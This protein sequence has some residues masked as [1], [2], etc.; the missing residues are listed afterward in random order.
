MN[1]QSLKVQESHFKNL[2]S[3]ILVQAKKSG[4]TDAEASMHYTSGLAA[5]VRMGAVD[6]VEFNKDK[7][8]ELTIYQGTRKGTVSTTDIHR[9]AIQRTI[10]AALRIAK[11][12]EEDACAGLADL[13]NLVTVFPDLDLYHPKVMGPEEAIQL[14]MECEAV[15]RA[16]DPRITQS[17]GATFAMHEGLRAYGN[18][19]GFIGSYSSTRYAL[20]CVLVA[21]SKGLRQRDYDFTTARDYNDLES[22]TLIGRRA[23]E[24]T[25]N[26]LDARK[27]KTDQV[28]VIFSKEI[29]GGIWQE[30]ISAISGG[31]LYRRSSFLV[32]HLG[33]SIFPHF[34]HI[35]EAPHLLKGLGSAP[36]DQ[37][38]VGTKRHDIVREGR[39][40]SYVLGSYSARK[41][42]LKTTG[43]SGGV[44]NVLVSSGNLDLNGLLKKM[45]RGLLITELMGHGVNLVTGDYS[46]G[47]TGFWVEG[48][49]IQYPVEEITVAGNLKDMFLNISDIG[50]DIEHRTNILTGSL[51][52]ENMTIGGH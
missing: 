32:D 47:A 46:R 14:A 40:E 30:F 35:E 22:A 15:A 2:I 20:S 25:V 12:T 4:A 36:F 27:V 19:H 42:G 50:C 11:Y 8:L 6:T 38:G 18:T 3:D 9:D 29:A 39:L 45:D 48:G 33:K 34:V 17:K 10:E 21:E 43:N 51:L 7:T 44:H 5:T 37:E 28:P 31:N 41:L 16:T 24:R 1:E 49:A 23:A 52:L 26:R 13:E